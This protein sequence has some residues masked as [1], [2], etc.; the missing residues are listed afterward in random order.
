MAKVCGINHVQLAMPAG[1]ENLARRFYG[2][3]LGLSEIPK[4]PDMAARGG[5]WFQCGP[6]QLHLGVEAEFRP[7]KKAHPALMVEGLDHFR[8][9]LKTAG[10][11]VKCDE[12]LAGFQRLFTADPFGNRIEL[13]EP[14]SAN[15]QS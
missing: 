3:L 7:A 15:Q 9:I 2:E 14:D 5:A 6:L 1:G 13:M 8:E 11:A 4:P 10:H 12:P